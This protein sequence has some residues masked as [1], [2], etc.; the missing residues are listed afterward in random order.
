MITIRLINKSDTRQEFYVFQQPAQQ[1]EGA[2]IGSGGLQSGALLHSAQS[3]SVVIFTIFPQADACMIFRVQ[4]GSF[5]AGTGSNA[6]TP[7]NTAVCDATQGCT[8]FDV[9]YG[10]DGCWSVYPEHENKAPDRASGGEQGSDPGLGTPWLNGEIRDFTGATVLCE[11]SIGNF[12]P[13][14]FATNLSNPGALTL[15]KAYQVGPSGG[16]YVILMYAMYDGTTAR[17]F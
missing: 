15:Y 8:E 2:E 12:A 16:P 5:S 13:P 1:S 6:V 9:I 7:G 17:F 3:G 14:V 10:A 11:C 4:A